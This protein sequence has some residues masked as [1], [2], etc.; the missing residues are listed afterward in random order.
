[1]DKQIKEKLEEGAIL[2]SAVIEIAGKPEKHIIDTM[3]LLLK[4]L[5]ENKVF[6]IVEKTVHPAAKIEGSEEMYSTFTEL[7]ILTEKADNINEFVQQYLPA[8]IEIIEP[9]H[10]Q[11]T[12]VEASGMY[13]DII[14]RLHH[15]DMQTRTLAQ[16]NK[17]MS[18][19]LATLIKNAI[20]IYLAPKSR[21]IEDISKVVGV[22]VEE[23]R[24]FVDLLVADNKI[25]LEKEHTYK[26][27]RQ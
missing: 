27:A 17:I 21:T 25:E 23:L 13:N 24:K 26:L 20:L 10:I 12:N 3:Q 11:L 1:M 14:A 15:N 22:P 5:P 9:E 19:D 6:E 18:Q 2:F 4:R 8:S 16:Q 7:T